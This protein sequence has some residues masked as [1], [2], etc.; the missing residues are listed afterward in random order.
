MLLSSI[1]IAQKCKPLISKK[2]KMT[3]Y[4]FEAWGGNLNTKSSLLYGQG[5]KMNLI[6]SKSKKAENPPY[7]TLTIEHIVANDSNFFDVNYEEGSE[8]LLKTRNDLISIPMEIV[9]KQNSKDK[10]KFKIT[11]RIFGDVSK[12]DLM[13]LADSPLMM[14]RIFAEDG[15]KIEREIS[16]KSGVKLQNQFSCLYNDL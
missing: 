16:S 15:T 10:H 14:I 13:K 12:D 7:A 1:S 8:F 6:I 4:K 5:F 11:F 9:K 3:G 2:D